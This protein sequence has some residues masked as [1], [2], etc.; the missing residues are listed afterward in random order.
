MHKSPKLLLAVAGTLLWVCSS[1]CQTAGSPG[2]EWCSRPDTASGERHIWKLRSCQHCRSVQ[3]IEA[4]SPPIFTSIDLTRIVGDEWKWEYRGRNARTCQHEWRAGVSRAVSTKISSGRVVLVR[5]GDVYGCFMLTEQSAKPETASFVWRH[6][7][8][9]A[10]GFDP[11]DPGVEG[12]DVAKSVQNRQGNRM[13]EFGPFEIQWS[14]SLGGQ[15]WI[16]YAKSPGD[17][18]MKDDL[19]ICV[20]EEESCDAVRPRDPKWQYRRS[21]VDGE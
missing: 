12:S 9:A 5:K 7:T 10:G 2:S 4:L 19:A 6:G 3:G 11:E 1:S 18:L 13:I 17:E 14:G 21:P 16:Y 20:T 15:S 8:D